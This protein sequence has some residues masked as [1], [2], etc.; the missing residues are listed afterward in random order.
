MQGTSLLWLFSDYYLRGYSKFCWAVLSKEKRM[1]RINGLILSNPEPRR[2]ENLSVSRQISRSKQLSFNFRKYASSEPHWPQYCLY[3]FPTSNH[4]PNSIPSITL[5]MGIISSDIY[6]RHHSLSPKKHVKSISCPS[7]LEHTLDRFR[8]LVKTVFPDVL[9][10]GIREQVL[11]RHSSPYK[12][13]TIT[14]C[15][16]GKIK[17]LTFVELIS[18]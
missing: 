11:N 4:D 8:E 1:G 9:N 10:H 17:Y 7:V 15:S 16:T 5:S 6:L 2:P 18:L 13:S 14:S 12:E 3:N